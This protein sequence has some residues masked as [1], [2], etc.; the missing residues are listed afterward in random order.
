MGITFQ[1]A[2]ANRIIFGTQTSRTI[3]DRASM[4]GKR[5]FLIIGSNPQ[6]SQWLKDGLISK[7]LAVEII[8]ISG[9]PDVPAVL[10]AVQQARQFKADVV[11]G[12][13]GGSVLDTGKVVSAMLTN[14]GDL[15]DYLEVIGHGRAIQKPPVPYIAVPSTAGTGTEVTKN[16]VITSPEHRVKVS[17]RH[18]WMIPELA[19]ID[20]E[21]TY[22]IPSD[23]T[24]STGLD[25][26]TQLI[27]PY[28]SRKHNPM[29]DAV[30]EEGLKR[31]AESIQ[32]VYDNG[33]DPGARENM[34]IASLFGGLALANA[35]LGAVHGIAGPM[36]GMFPVPHGVVCA[37]LLP[38]VMETNLRIL[39]KQH[40]D[41]M[42]IGCFHRLGRLLTGNYHASSEDALTWIQNLCDHLEVRPLSEFGVRRE[43]FPEIIQKSMKASS[44]QGNPVRLNEDD[45][46]GILEKAV[47]SDAN[48]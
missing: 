4:W 32:K 42:L 18:A 16:A 22:S 14:D 39:Q 3:P 29:T 34:A 36:G 8:S 38:Y 20:P 43:A 13:G 41:S 12:I 11:V 2:T 21:L 24:A 33:N 26:L 19:V 25:A 7:K 48:H 35:K 30:C 17:M 31:A 23:V 40:S 1:F 44:M 37:R 28:L 9:E 15:M 5:I 46:K 45:L 6:R 27:E 47:Y 10:E